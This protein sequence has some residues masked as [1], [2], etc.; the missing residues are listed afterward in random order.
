MKIH[1]KRI[2]ISGFIFALSLI[3]C[4]AALAAEKSK[5]NIY[6]PTSGWLV[7]P[8]SIDESQDSVKMPCLVAN[9]FSNGF[10]VRLSGGGGQL[11][12]M[13]IDF[14]QKA[15]TPRQK[16]EV[17]ISVP[18]DY[19]QMMT[20]AAFDAG[21]LIFGLEKYRDFY[22]VLQKADT[23]TIKAEGM[24]VALN[25]MGLN[26]GFRRMNQCYDPSGDRTQVA[27]RTPQKPLIAEANRLLP[28]PGEEDM[29][30]VAAAPSEPVRA[31]PLKKQV[32]AQPAAPV[33]PAAAL[34]ARAKAAEQAGKDLA[35]RGRETKVAAA[36][37][38]AE[39][40]QPAP[41]QQ[42][43]DILAERPGAAVPL[44]QYSEGKVMRWRAMRGS[45]LHDVL[46][47][48]VGAIGGK[49]MWGPGQEFTVQ[50]SIS[51]SGDFQTAI[52]TLLDQYGGL[53][54][55]PVGRIDRDPANGQVILVIDRS[56]APQ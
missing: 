51:M 56:G 37:A 52:R 35:Q 54:V 40:K 19:M 24:T 1:F 11:M 7:G 17:E 2:E 28:M 45:D 47:Q 43:G 34:I 36:P 3:A 12:A 26:D 16:Y 31:T 13:A 14:R 55:R 39:P 29:P 9:Q 27:A 30:M 4:T 46:N 22:K 50:R 8:A 41:A 5:P 10:V 49:L 21:T 44:G 6:V 23:L 53:P 20:G 15:F 33:D 38:W 48:W 32:V 42:N 25:L 18:G